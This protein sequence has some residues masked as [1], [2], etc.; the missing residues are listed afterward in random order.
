MNFFMWF[1]KKNFVK[2]IIILFIVGFLLYMKYGLWDIVNFLIYINF[3]VYGYDEV[4]VGLWLEWWIV[5]YIF[6]FIIFMFLISM[7]MGLVF[8]FL[9][10][11]GER[12]GFIIIVLLSY[13]VFLIII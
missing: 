13:I 10:E 6:S 3:I 5:F 8:L 2:I 1:Y 9:L 4:I 11:F 12:V 7:L